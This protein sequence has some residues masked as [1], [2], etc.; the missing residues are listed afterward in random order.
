MKLKKVIATLLISTL[1][2]SF[3]AAQEPVI[4]QSPPVPT[5]KIDP[6]PTK[7]QNDIKQE[8]EQKKANKASKSTGTRNGRQPEKNNGDPAIISAQKGGRNSKHYQD[9]YEE[10]DDDKN[11][12]DSH[13]KGIS[14]NNTH[15]KSKTITIIED[16]KAKDDDNRDKFTPIFVTC[17]LT[18]V[19]AVLIL[20]ILSYLRRR[21]RIA[22]QSLAIQEYAPVRYNAPKANISGPGSRRPMLGEAT[23]PG[24]RA[25]PEIVPHPDEQ[26]QREKKNVAPKKVD[27][28][29]SINGFVDYQKEWTV[30]GVSV[31]G[32]GHADSGLTC[33]DNNGFLYLGDGW[34]IAV[35][36]DGAGSAANSQIGS[37]VT[38]MRTIEHFK[39]LIASKHWID[40]NVLPSDEEWDEAVYFTLRNVKDDIVRF[41]KEKNIEVSSLNATVIVVICSPLGLLACHVGDGRAGYCTPSGQWRSL[42]TPHK[43]EE[44]NQT[45]FLSSDFWNKPYFKLSG[46]RVPEA[47]VVRKPVAA[48]TLMSD[49]CE[50]ICWECNMYN[51]EEKHFFDPNRPFANFFNSVVNTLRR[52]R[53]EGA[54]ERELLKAWYEFIAAGNERFRNETDDRTLLLGVTP[55]NIQPRK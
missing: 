37:K 7:E 13:S 15:T 26:A 22:S 41:A 55:S 33:Q 48:F 8:E 21:K 27:I 14:S 46:V 45:I 50:N 54:S 44:A 20:L 31:I 28:P 6:T 2:F 40:D 24:L 23:D 47:I 38:V 3:V 16:K 4:S 25:I 29:E 43:G 52:Q 36:S 18:L 32:N 5:D 11:N 49:G 19:A 17:M 9:F 51:E 10:L 35:T 12:N 53:N 1:C 30:V 34:G 42:I 39:N